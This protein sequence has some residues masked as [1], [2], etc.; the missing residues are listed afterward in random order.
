MYG[1]DK[2][3]CMMVMVTRG[4]LFELLVTHILPVSRRICNI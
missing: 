1:C 2:E 3:I 4:L